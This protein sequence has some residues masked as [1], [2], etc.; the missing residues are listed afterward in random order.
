MQLKYLLSIF[1]ETRDKKYLFFRSGN[2]ELI[3]FGPDP[4]FLVTILVTLYFGVIKS[5]IYTDSKSSLQKV[6]T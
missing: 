1:D 4:W 6:L 3:A 5:V 2:R